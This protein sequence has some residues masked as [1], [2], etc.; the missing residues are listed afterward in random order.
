MRLKKNL[1]LDLIY[2]VIFSAGILL[3]S[4]PLNR[5]DQGLI[6][7]AKNFVSITILGLWIKALA[8]EY[9]SIF[10]IKDYPASKNSPFK[11]SYT[12]LRDF[13]EMKIACFLLMYCVYAFSS[14]AFSIKTVD[15]ELLRIV[16]IGFY[17]LFILLICTSYL[18]V[19]PSHWYFVA[20]T[21][22][23][24]LLSFIIATALDLKDTT[25]FAILPV[26]FE[27]LFFNPPDM[28]KTIII[29][30]LSAIIFVLM[31]LFFIKAVKR[32]LTGTKYLKLDSTRVN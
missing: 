30:G 13:L 9:P 16:L 26:N 5:F 31:I 14:K 12:L 18:K 22:G 20:L 29:I 4:N 1:V 8:R 3:N 2:S 27:L 6:F 21:L 10:M 23:P 19:P 24:F 11:S 28:P 17:T 32:L 25:Y 7:M 15:I